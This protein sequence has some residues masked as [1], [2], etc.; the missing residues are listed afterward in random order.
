MCAGRIACLRALC[1]AYVCV[2][3]QNI[4]LRDVLPETKDEIMV[5]LRAGGVEELVD[6]DSLDRCGPRS[7][8]GH[9][10]AKRSHQHI[11]SASGVP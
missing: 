5:M 8:A 7:A 1:F 10:A 9:G 2:W 4:I 11:G 6:W 3:V